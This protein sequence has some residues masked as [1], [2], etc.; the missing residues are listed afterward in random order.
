VRLQQFGFCPEPLLPFHCRQELL[1]W[2]TTALLLLKFE[3]ILVL[4]PFGNIQWQFQQQLH[5]EA[6]IDFLG[7]TG[8]AGM[9]FH[10]LGG[11]EMLS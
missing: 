10:M 5:H 4:V 9:L 7:Q 11:I 3:I 6:E 2:P 8:L 1:R